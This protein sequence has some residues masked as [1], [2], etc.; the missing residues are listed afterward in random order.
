[1]LI[2]KVLLINLPEEGS[3]ADFYTPSYTIGSFSTYPPLG[4]LYIATAIKDKYPVE[5]LDTVALKYSTEEIVKKIIEKAPDV[6]GIS[7]QTMRLYPAF[8]IL[9]KVKKN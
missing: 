3:C 6:L 7:I 5:I 2:K 9:N 1:M 8:E 4:L